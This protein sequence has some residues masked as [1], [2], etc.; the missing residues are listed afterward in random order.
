MGSQ[1]SV[2]TQQTHKGQNAGPLPSSRPP[3]WCLC[4]PPTSARRT[5]WR[6]YSWWWS[7]ARWWPCA[8]RWPCA[9]WWSCARWWPCPWWPCAR[10]RPVLHRA[11][12]VHAIARPVAVAGAYAAA[13]PLAEVSPYN[14]NYAVSDDYSGS[15]F[16]AS[17]G[18]DGLGTKSGSY[19]VALPDGRTQTVNYNTNDVDGYV[20]DVAYDGVPQYA[21]VAAPLAVAHPTLVAHPAAGLFAHPHAGLVAHP[22]TTI[23]G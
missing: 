23:I 4:R 1:G 13:D 14:F 20:A 18:S 17:E 19:S 10:C 22:A 16:T 6:P 3:C 15:S 9:Q 12:L 11:P 7:C 2:T 21:P 8:R 5:H